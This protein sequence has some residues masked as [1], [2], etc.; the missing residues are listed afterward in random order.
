MDDWFSVSCLFFLIRTM[1]STITFLPID[2]YCTSSYTRRHSK[3]HETFGGNYDDLSRLFQSLWYD[4]FQK[5]HHQGFPTR[6]FKLGFPRD[7][8]IWTLNHITHRKRFVQIDDKCSEI[9]N[10]NFKVPQG[11]ILG[12]VLFN[13]YVADLQE[14]VKVKCFQYAD[15]TTIYDHA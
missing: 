10:V 11:S 13:I 4:L 12:P 8:L 7:F 6:N 14:N 5:S 2:Y 9:E 1:F 3:S 15:N